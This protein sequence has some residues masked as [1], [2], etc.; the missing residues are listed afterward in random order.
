VP[1]GIGLVPFPLPSDLVPFPRI[2]SVSISFTSH[3][4]LFLVCFFPHGPLTVPILNIRLSGSIEFRSHDSLS[5]FL[6]FECNPPLTE[7]PD[8]FPL[9]PKPFP[10]TILISMRRTRSSRELFGFSLFFRFYVLVPSFFFLVFAHFRTL[11]YHANFRHILQGRK[12]TGWSY[13]PFFPPVPQ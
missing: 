4:F 8:A 7:T 13:P 2:F 5:P 3:S 11:G 12:S 10:V 6:F 9:F 1:L